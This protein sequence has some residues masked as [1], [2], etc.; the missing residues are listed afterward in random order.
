MAHSS[1]DI[2]DLP[3]N[4]T[5]PAFSDTLKQPTQQYTRQ[6]RGVDMESSTYRQLNPHQNPYMQ[7][8]PRLDTMPLP[9]RGGSSGMMPAAPPSYNF[10]Q[11]PLGKSPSFSLPPKDIPIDMASFRDESAKPN[12][13]PYSKQ[14]ED[15]VSNQEERIRDNKSSEQTIKSMNEKM[16]IIAEFQIPI[17]VALLFM[18][19]Q[20]NTIN[21]L[22]ARHLKF[23]GFFGE[24]GNLNSSGVLFKSALFGAIYYALM[25]YSKWIE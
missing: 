17:V 16:D 7:G 23:A 9:E 25:N 4:I 24:D 1:T 18:I 5:M 22:M 6:D 11:G 15:Y 19:F 3:E 21:T 12:Y 13:V 2:M 10:D 14:K 20:V 8:Q